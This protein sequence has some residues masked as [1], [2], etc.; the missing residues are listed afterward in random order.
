[1]Y[2]KEIKIFRRSRTQKEYAEYLGVPLR[3]VQNWE[4]R[5]TG[6]NTINLLAKIHRQ[7]LM[8]ERLKKQLE[9]NNM[10]FNL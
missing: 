3:A 2:E 4:S 5:G 7:E 8:I 9:D 6:N 10:T 1:M